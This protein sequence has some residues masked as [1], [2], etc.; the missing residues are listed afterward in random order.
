M[1]SN[2]TQIARILDF[3]PYFRE[4]WIL[5]NFYKIHDEKCSFLLF[6]TTRV[7]RII[8]NQH[9]SVNVLIAQIFKKTFILKKQN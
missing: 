3:Y 7:K 2:D 1:L 9:I 5:N 4:T 8:W 6:S